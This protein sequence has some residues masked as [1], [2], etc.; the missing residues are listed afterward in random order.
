M[1]HWLVTWEATNPALLPARRLAL[2]LDSRRPA[3][4][5]RRIVESLYISHSFSEA[6]ALS[7]VRSNPYPAE[8]GAVDGKTFEGQITCGHNPHLFARLVEKLKVSA[9][10]QLEWQERPWKAPS[11]K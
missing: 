2:V 7:A 1:A 6:D 5:V 3:K 4:E 9:A 10:G 11:R 8:F